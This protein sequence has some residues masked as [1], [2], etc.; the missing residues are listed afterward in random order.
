MQGTSTTDN[1]VRLLPELDQ[2]GLNVKIVAAIS[3]QLF[4]L[5]DKRYRDEVASDDPDIGRAALAAML[6]Y[7]RPDDLT[8]LYEFIDRRAEDDPELTAKIKERAAELERQWQEQM[9]TF[10]E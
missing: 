5:Q 7:T 6:P 4:R 9:A 10:D 1:V 8:V 3:P 2:T